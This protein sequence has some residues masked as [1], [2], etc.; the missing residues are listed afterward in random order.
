MLDPK[1]QEARK[2][3][4]D[5]MDRLAE[6][7]RRER[8]EFLT[9]VVEMGFALATLSFQQGMSESA[10]RDFG[11]YLRD[12][13]PGFTGSSL[14][15]NARGTFHFNP[16]TL[17]GYVEEEDGSTYPIPVDPERLDERVRELTEIYHAWQTRESR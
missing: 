15:N 16:E 8:I 4:Q 10:Q 3:F 2:R 14:R 9:P 13:R 7:A 17:E 6:E 5:E 12:H 1:F 11:I